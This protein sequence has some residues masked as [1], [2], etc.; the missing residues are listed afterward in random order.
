MLLDPERDLGLPLLQ[1]ARFFVLLV[2][3]NSPE[4]C[5]LC[6]SLGD[7]RRVELTADGVESPDEFRYRLFHVLLERDVDDARHVRRVLDKSLL[8]DSNAL[9]GQRR[10]EHSHFQ[11]N[12]LTRTRLRGS[13]ALLLG[14]SNI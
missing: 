12:V 9:S 10:K 1:L 6:R 2:P 13:I 4:K 7:L 8:Q 14:I 3:R 11:N 5:L